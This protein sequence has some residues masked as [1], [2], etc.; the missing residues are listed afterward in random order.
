MHKN[1]CNCG[2]IR[3]ESPKSTYPDKSKSTLLPIQRILYSISE[4]IN[5]YKS[6]NE[7]LIHSTETVDWTKRPVKNP[8]SFFQAED[9]VFPQFYINHRDGPLFFRAASS[10]T[11]LSEVN[12]E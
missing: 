8:F 3:Q 11:N 10:R 7:S 12:Y 5:S 2:N 6:L 1:M 4:E 9:Q